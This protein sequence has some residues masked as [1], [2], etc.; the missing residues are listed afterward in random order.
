MSKIN[1][2][3]VRIGPFTDN[4]AILNAKELGW[5]ERQ[6]ANGLFQGEVLPFL[7]PVLQEISWQAGV[8]N[9]STMSTRISEPNHYLRVIEHVLH[10]IEMRIQE[11]I[12][13]QGFAP[14]FERQD[15]KGFGWAH[16]EPLRV[17]R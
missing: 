11:W 2:V 15:D 4:A 7:H 6:F 3:Q 8:H 9:L 13:E 10:G 5:I 16:V 1:H 17:R 12:I 14:A